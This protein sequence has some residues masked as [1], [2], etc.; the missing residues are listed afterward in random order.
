MRL[1]IAYSKIKKRNLVLINNDTYQRE[2]LSEQP[3]R[4]PLTQFKMVFANNRLICLCWVTYF[5][6][7]V[8]AEIVQIHEKSLS[9]N[10]WL[11]PKYKT[12]EK[13]LLTYSCKMPTYWDIQWSNSIFFYEMNVVDQFCINKCIDLRLC[14]FHCSI[15]HYIELI[16]GFDTL[17]VKIALISD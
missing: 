8:S 2:T 9:H 16:V 3:I 6:S 1:T 14:V 4:Q 17:H 5:F 13:V 10:H 7:P 11:S 12:F 15:D